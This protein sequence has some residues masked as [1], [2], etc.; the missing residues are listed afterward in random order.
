MKTS[1]LLI[2]T[3]AFVSKVKVENSSLS[4]IKKEFAKIGIDFGTDYIKKAIKTP[5][6][7]LIEYAK[8]YGIKKITEYAYMFN[9]E[10]IFITEIEGGNI[11]AFCMLLGI[12]LFSQQNK[13][14][15]EQCIEKNIFQ[16]IDKTEQIIE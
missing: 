6:E 10:R 15:V 11:S 7:R 12:S 13:E 1:D 5:K 14:I 4:E 3:A 16:L 8:L 2:D 9:G